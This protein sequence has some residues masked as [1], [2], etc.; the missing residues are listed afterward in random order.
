MFDRR[1]FD[2]IIS[3][4]PAEEPADRPATPEHR[5]PPERREPALPRPL[6]EHPVHDAGSARRQHE[7]QRQQPERRSPSPLHQPVAAPPRRLP[8]LRGHHREPEEAAPSRRVDAPLSD[9]PDLELELDEV[10]VLR[11]ALQIRPDVRGHPDELLGV[12]VLAEDV[13]NLVETPPDRVRSV[14]A[15][16]EQRVRAR[17]Y[18]LQAPRDLGGEAR[19]HEPRFLHAAHEARLG[20]EPPQLHA[21]PPPLGQPGDEPAAT[22]SSRERL[23]ASSTSSHRP[24]RAVGLP[25]VHGGHA[26]GAVDVAAVR[27]DVDHPVQAPLEE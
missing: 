15:P 21:A 22:T 17:Q 6:H 18:R 14:S 16:P 20:D 5:E 26:T 2:P 3:E 12:A 19:L 13:P 4:E 11:G 24:Q 8:R 10:T 27:A 9:L 1:E 7:R 25:V 23:H